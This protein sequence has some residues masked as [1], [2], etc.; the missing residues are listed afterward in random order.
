MKLHF[1]G[2]EDTTKVLTTNKNEN[3]TILLLHNMETETIFTKWSFENIYPEN[4]VD[5]ENNPFEY[6]VTTR[7]SHFINYYLIT[8]ETWINFFQSHSMRK[9]DL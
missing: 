9:H 3:K 1:D 5:E 7:K 4:Q 8:S 2:W 6:T